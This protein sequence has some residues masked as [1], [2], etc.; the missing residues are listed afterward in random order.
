[1]VRTLRAELGI[2]HGTG[3]R[4]AAQL[5][6]GVE[7]VRRWVKQ[8]DIDDGAAPTL[9]T[10][11]LTMAPSTSYAAK[12]RPVSAREGRDAELRSA[13]R[14]LGEDTYRVYGH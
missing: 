5:G 1:M 14:A 10:V 11:G 8:A 6:Y 9:S 4:V 3:Q 7:W 12:S 2:E 13:L